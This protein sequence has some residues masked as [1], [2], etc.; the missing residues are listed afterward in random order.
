M[1][2]PDEPPDARTRNIKTMHWRI[3][4]DKAQRYNQLNAMYA[5]IQMKDNAFE[6]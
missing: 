4:R 5:Q 1:A 6:D 2:I 3:E